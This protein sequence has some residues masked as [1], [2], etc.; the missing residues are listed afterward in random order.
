MLLFY[1]LYQY[2]LSHFLINRDA[3]NYQN[4]NMT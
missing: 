4:N 1:F 3:L 2:D